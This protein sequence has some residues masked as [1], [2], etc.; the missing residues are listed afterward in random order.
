MMGSWGGGPSFYQKVIAIVRV[1]DIG[2]FE[3][4]IA[5]CH[6]DMALLFS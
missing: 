2:T 4:A 1:Q 3:V 6:D 5:S